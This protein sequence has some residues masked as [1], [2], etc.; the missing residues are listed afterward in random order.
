MLRGFGDFK[1]G[2]KKLDENEYNELV[3]VFKEHPRKIDIIEKAKKKGKWGP[4]DEIGESEE[5]RRLKEYVAAN[6]S[7]VLGE[8][9]LET[10]KIEYCFPSGDRADIVLKDINGNIIGAEIEINV[11]STQLAG[12][13]QA[14]KYRYML[15]LMEERKNFETRAFLIAKSISKDMVN[16]CDKYDVE[17][18]IISSREPVSRI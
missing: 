9:G 13:L 17:C 18:F 11:D 5:H 4:H 7:A 16:L 1:S 12:I 8:R 2:L 15:A 6:P 14:I 3:S 10:V